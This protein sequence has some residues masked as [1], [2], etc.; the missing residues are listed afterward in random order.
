LGLIS[1]TRFNKPRAVTHL[2]IDPAPRPSLTYPFNRG[3]SP[4]P[5]KPFEVSPGVFWLRVPLPISLD[6]I[7]LW[8]LKDGDQWVIVDSGFDD[9]VC[10]E[11][12]ETVFDEFLEPELVSRIIITHY[13]PDHIGLASWLAHRCHCKVHITRGEFDRYRTIVDRA[14][15]DSSGE[16]KTFLQQMGFSDRLQKIYQEFFKVDEKPPEARV[17]EHD[18][19]FIKADDEL[20]IGNKQWRVIVGNGHSPEHACLYCEELGLMISGDQALPRISSNISVYYSNRDQNPL[21]DWLESCARLRDTVPS[22]TLILP[23]HQEPF[24]GIALRMQQLLDDHAAQLN[25]L[26]LRLTQPMTAAEAHQLVFERELSDVEILLATGE[27][28]AHL[29]YLIA[30]DEVVSHSSDDGRT[31][32]ALKQ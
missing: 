19:V 20:L 23:A 9:A 26:R 2:N 14:T 29:N 25:K 5:G 24:I 8:L 1:S 6:H 28:L 32:Y 17:Q 18:C 12:W 4:E 21:A 30:R 3:F 16:I 15:S 10:L 7:N 11:T 31:R 13:H 22:S 27:T